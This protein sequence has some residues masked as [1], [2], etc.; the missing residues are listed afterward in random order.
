MGRIGIFTQDFKFY[1]DVIFCLKEWDL[2]FVSIEDPEK[3]P[4]DVV[5]VLSSDGDMSIPK[6]VKSVEANRAIRMALPRLLN[7]FHF[8][9]VVIGIDPGP[10]PGI[11]VTA[12]GVLMEAFECPDIRSMG[13]EVSD[14]AEFYAYRNISIKMGNGDRPNRMEIMDTLEGTKIGVTIVDE[15]NTSVPHRIH[16]NA[17]SAARIAFIEGNSYPLEI[18]R[19]FSRKD[20][21][22]REFVT[23]QKLVLASQSG[24]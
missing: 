21:Y 1:H 6:Q 24:S 15:S 17:L 12:D 13:R 16:D 2:P 10:R 9:S 14:I 18:P 20:V 3:I 5:V 8:E 23:I 11:A 19:K 7:R 22:D 4:P